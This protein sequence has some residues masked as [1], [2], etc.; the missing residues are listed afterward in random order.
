MPGLAETFSVYLGDYGVKAFAVLLLFINLKEIGKLFK[1][2]KIKS[3][4]VIIL[5]L[6][7][8]RTFHVT[9]AVQQPILPFVSLL[10]L[11]IIYLSIKT[12]K[13]FKIFMFCLYAST[14]IVLLSPGLDRIFDFSRI[15]YIESRHENRSK[16]FF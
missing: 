10:W 2:S 7:I 16:W 5:L 9:S 6:F 12:D 3:L 11:I 13:H 1:Y 8:Y 14:C 15:G 4:I